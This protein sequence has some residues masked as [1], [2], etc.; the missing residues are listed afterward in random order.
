MK[1][2]HQGEYH[3]TLEGNNEILLNDHPFLEGDPAKTP[4]MQ[5]TPMAA[6]DTKPEEDDAAEAASCKPA[7]V[8]DPVF[9]D[10]K[11]VC[12]RCLLGRAW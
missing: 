11:R 7:K 5:R 4:R 8:P 6:D 2:H 1:M 12:L 9:V 3:I 10:G